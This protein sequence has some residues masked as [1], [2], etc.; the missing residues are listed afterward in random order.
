VTAIAD[1]TVKKADGT[2]DIVWPAV[3]GA[4]GDKSPAV[5]RSST[6][7]GTTGQKPF[8]QM[9]A[10][11]NGD[12]TARRIDVLAQYPGVYTNSSTGQT[13]VRA[14]AI[15]NFSVVIPQNMASTDINELSAQFVNLLASSQF[16]LSLSSGYAP[17]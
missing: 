4:G 16:K 10:R 1:I 11:W 9:S 14:K 6:S 2:T 17:T 7:P 8:I 15:M 12:N 3:A 13:E 5:W